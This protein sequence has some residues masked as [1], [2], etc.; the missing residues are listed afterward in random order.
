MLHT[1]PMRRFLDLFAAM[2][3][4]QGMV[5]ILFLLGIVFFFGSRGETN[6]KTNLPSGPLTLFAVGDSLTAGF[7]VAENQ[8]YPA[9]LEQKIYSDNLVKHTVVNKGVSGETSAELL[10]RIDALIAQ[11]PDIIL[12]MI[13][14]NDLLQRKSL[15]ELESNIE[16]IIQK[17]KA[18]EIVLVFA[19][20]KAPP[21]VAGTYGKEF[22]QIYPRL[23]KKY[24]LVFIP[25]FLKGVQTNPSFNLSDLIHPNAE[26]YQRIVEKNIWPVLSKILK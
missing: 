12:F 2:T 22:A 23:A 7:G 25:N 10:E 19:G 18:A 4:K 13:G 8:S 9:M 5:L 1:E 21:L 15:G 6:L 26:G 20:M 16:T 24:D 3:L 11:D 14:G 17:I